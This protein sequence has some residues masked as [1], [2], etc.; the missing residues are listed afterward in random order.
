LRETE[1]KRVQGQAI[2]T[3][4][5]AHELHFVHA[6]F[7]ETIRLQPPVG[8]DFRI[9]VSND[10]LPS[11]ISVRDGTRVFMPN[12]AIGRDPKLW[13]SAESFVP[14]RWMSYDEKGEAQRVRRPDEYVLPVFWSGPRLCLGKDMARFE[15]TVF[16]AKI[17]SKLDVISEPGQEVNNDYVMGPVIFYQNGWKAR[18]QAIA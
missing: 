3:F 5:A 6:V 12:V 13:S 1:F 11:G 10:V 15:A 18:M 8:V 9:C 16:C 7:N 17:F 14:E 4:D 2:I